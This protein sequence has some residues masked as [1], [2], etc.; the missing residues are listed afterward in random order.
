MKIIRAMLLSRKKE[1]GATMV[2]FALILPLFLILVF[3][4]I[5]FSFLLY[6]KGII[7]HAA[8]EGARVGVV[9]NFP[10]RIPVG[11]ITSE[12]NRYIEGNLISLGSP[13]N[14]PNVIVSRCPTGDPSNCNPN[15]VCLDNDAYI[16]PAPKPK[17]KVEVEYTYSFLVV[18]NF[19]TN[20]VGDVNLQ[21]EA[22]M[23]CE[24]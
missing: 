1:S 18:P 9:Y 8:R 21:S 17:L 22:M 3:G 11:D 15:Q 12:V 10:D 5:E 4:I 24:Y 13:A 14:A 6:N 20:L 7:T 23:V 2:E 16:A 19:V